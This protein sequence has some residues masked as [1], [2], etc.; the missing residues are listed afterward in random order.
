MSARIGT[1]TTI[2]FGTSTFTADIVSAQ[3]DES[4]PSVPASHLGS[5][6]AEFLPGDL[7]ERSLTLTIHRK[8]G[9]NPPLSAD[10][11][12]ITLTSPEGETWVGSGFLTSVSS[13]FEIDGIQAANIGVQLTGDLAY[14]P[15]T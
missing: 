7:I 15:N 14:T 2:A 1:G 9:E 12:T 8:D 10:A 6:S 11:E 5:T 13:T 3:L 4:R